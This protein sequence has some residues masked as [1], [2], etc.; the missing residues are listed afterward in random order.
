MQAQPAGPAQPQLPPPMLPTP[1]AAPAQTLASP[2]PPP[3]SR[4]HHALPSDGAKGDS[5]TQVG[6]HI[7]CFFFGGGGGFPSPISEK[8]AL[9]SFSFFLTSRMSSSGFCLS[10]DSFVLSLT[11]RTSRRGDRY[12]TSL[13]RSASAPR[14]PLFFFFCCHALLSFLSYVLRSSFLLISSICASVPLYLWL[15]GPPRGAPVL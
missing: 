5:A 7:G 14:L 12:F 3:R 15:E 9:L 13:L 8:T 2:K 1:A 10:C 4:S 6:D 11:S